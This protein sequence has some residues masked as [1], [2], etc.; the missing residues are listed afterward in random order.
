MYLGR[1]VTSTDGAEYSP[2]KPKFLTLVFVCGDTVCFLVQS[3]GGGIIASAKKASEVDLGQH[4]ILGGLILQIVA[5][6]FFVSVAVRFHIR[7]SAAKRAQAMPWQRL[8]YSLYVLSFFIVLRNVVRTV[9]YGGKSNDYLLTHEWVLLVFDGACMILVLGISCL[10]YRTAIGSS[11]QDRPES[12]QACLQGYQSFEL[13]QK[14][15]T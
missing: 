5:F 15:S 3:G 2:I 10:W 12:S 6:V 7:M 9:E 13:R 8:L 1:V 14:H 4:I 11:R